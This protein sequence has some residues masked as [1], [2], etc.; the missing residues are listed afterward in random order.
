MD[1][2]ETWSLQK[3]EDEVSPSRWNPRKS[4]DEV[5]KEYVDTSIL[6][7]HSAQET[8]PHELNI[9][10][11]EKPSQ[12]YDLYGTDLSP[13]SH[14]YIWIHGGYWQEGSKDISALFASTLH[15]QGV[16]NI[17]LGYTLAPA[18]SIAQIEEEVVLALK[19]IISK[20][21]NSPIIIG[22]HSA[23]AQLASMILHNQ[24]DP[25][26]VEHIKEFHFVSGV[27]DLRPLI[28]TYVNNPL[29]LTRSTADASSPLRIRKIQQRF[30]DKGADLKI[31]VTV[32][33]HD[34]PLFQ[35]QSQ[36]YYKLLRKAF[37]HFE[38][39]KSDSDDHFT[40]IQNMA[41]SNTGAGKQFHQQVSA[42][43]SSGTTRLVSNQ[44]TTLMS[45]IAIF[46]LLYT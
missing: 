1:E 44:V 37:S 35:Q 34:S 32:A 10:Y 40:L 19:E 28:P 26:I 42:L 21:P 3:L 7:T 4:P 25:V 39:W 27:Y 33:K 38:F 17:V 41:K 22:G 46:M 43:K 20:H 16:R 31:S 8:I 36:E 9:P 18:A 15:A 2:W 24:S 5:I 14:I 12:Q 29:K 45:I 6:G 23:G 11:G 30:L 13:D